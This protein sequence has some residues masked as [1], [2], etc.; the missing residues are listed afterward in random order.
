MLLMTRRSPSRA[1]YDYV[2]MRL[3]LLIILLE[4]CSPVSLFEPKQLVGFTSFEFSR[5]RGAFIAAPIG[6]RGDIKVRELC[7]ARDAQ[8]N[9][10]A[11]LR[12]LC[13]V[14]PTWYIVDS[15]LSPDRLAN[16]NACL[17]TQVCRIRHASGVQH[18]L[19]RQGRHAM[20]L[21]GSEGMSEGTPHQRQRMDTREPERSVRRGSKRGTAGSERRGRPSETEGYSHRGKAVESRARVSR[22]RGTGARPGSSARRQRMPMLSGISSVSGLASACLPLFAAHSHSNAT[23]VRAADSARILNRLRQLGGMRT[24]AGENLAGGSQGADVAALIESCCSVVM[25]EMRA[26][27]VGSGGG[28]VLE[29]KYAAMAANVLKQEALAHTDFFDELAS[30]IIFLPDHLQA[31]H[32]R[33]QGSPERAG[34]SMGRG[35]GLGAAR[36]GSGRGY[37]MEAQSV[38]M[39]VNAVTS[40]ALLAGAPGE[41]KERMTACLQVL[42]EVAGAHV[43]AATW[44]PQGLAMTIG[45]AGRALARLAAPQAG[46]GNEHLSQGTLVRIRGLDALVT[47]M[48]AMPPESLGAQAAATLAHGLA[49]TGCNDAAAMQHLAAAMC[50]APGHLWNG[51]TVA[52]A[53]MAFVD[54]PTQVYPQQVLEKLGTL[55]GELPH[56]EMDALA[57]IDLARSFYVCVCSIFRNRCVAA[58]T[59][60]RAMGCWSAYAMSAIA[61]L[62]CAV[63]PCA[64]C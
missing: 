27:R 64:G 37:A 46:T 6:L 56:S 59:L 45:G 22:T 55:A 5:C 1:H 61:M 19:P 36:G 43:D 39:L 8:S 47:A 7:Y 9:T 17:L 30:F 24:G 57:Y 3:G 20:S 58:V 4:S 53:S 21:G 23:R 41:T 62:P 25:R 26:S 60:L 35:G 10:L 51:Q 52:L 32:E 29:L 2:A 16:T 42:L 54:S 14:F 63:S 33:N 31:V 48:K 13:L 18:P 34:V 50:A 28:A 40:P 12:R 38:S 49:R 44:T 15:I 11:L